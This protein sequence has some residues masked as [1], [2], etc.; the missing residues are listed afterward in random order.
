MF[1]QEPNEFTT[2]IHIIDKNPRYH[3]ISQVFSSPKMST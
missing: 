1:Q 3:Q 2:K